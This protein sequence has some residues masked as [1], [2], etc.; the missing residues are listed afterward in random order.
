MYYARQEDSSGKIIKG[1]E[2]PRLNININVRNQKKE[3][4]DQLSYPGC[5]VTRDHFLEKEIETRTSKSST[6]F[7]QFTSSRHLV[8]EIYLKR[9]K[10]AV[11][12]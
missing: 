2:V 1:Q 4:I 8:S 5:Y 11:L 7:I 12:S 3:T 9:I 6:V 10:V